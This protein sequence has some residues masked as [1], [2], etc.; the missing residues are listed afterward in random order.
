MIGK[1]TPILSEIFS[2]ISLEEMPMH[3]LYVTTHAPGYS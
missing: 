1:F 2:L 3:V